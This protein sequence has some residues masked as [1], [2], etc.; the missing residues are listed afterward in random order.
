LMLALL[1]SLLTAGFDPEDQGRRSVAWRRGG[2][3]TPDGDGSFDIGG[4]TA[5]ALTAL[6][7]G[8]PAVD[9]GP[10]DDRACGNGSLMRI[11]P[12][13]LVGRNWS[14]DV[15]IERAQLASR[16][17]HGHP[18]CQVTCAVY[19]L[20]VRELLRGSAPAAALEWAMT[21]ARDAYAA[22]GAI[23]AASF[24]AALEELAAYQRRTGSGYVIDAFWSAWDAFAGA[25]DYA[26]TIVR[27]IEYGHDTDTTAA[28]AGGLAGA[29]WGWEGI[30]VAWRR[31]MRGHAVAQPLVDRLAG[32]VTPAEGG[33]LPTSTENPLRVDLLDLAGTP[34]EGTG[35]LG[36]TLLPGKK[37]EGWTG[38]HWRDLDLDLARLRD[39][40]V[41][42]LFLLNE[43]AELALCLVP[44]LPDAMAAVGPELV[45][46]PIPD[47]HVPA[48]PGAYRVA[49]RGLVERVRGGAFVAIACRGGI[50][51]SG[52]TAACI[53]RELGLDA[54][55]AIARTQAARRRSITIGEEQ[56]FVR[57]WPW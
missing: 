21:T 17:T 38:A 35:R 46:F 52:M 29:R 53:Y 13:A 31:G 19:C 7:A 18:R 26:Q 25:A 27:A 11:L 2:A 20:I 5:R 40:G 43:D 8:T 15:L 9:A 37:R 4:T 3:Y 1:D 22:D 55:E 49:I 23:P 42:T 24:R 45:R 30:P 34:L 41:D 14:P 56:A 6:G 16:V 54:S 33:P 48:D 12:I 32:T 39:L 50:N 28:I 10:A 57:A 47:P 51:R 36:I 44:E